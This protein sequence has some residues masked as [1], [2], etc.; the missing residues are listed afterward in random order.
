GAGGSP[1][2]TGL[3]AAQA[4]ASLDKVQGIQLAQATTDPT[5]PGHTGIATPYAIEVLLDELTVPAVLLDGGGLTHVAPL[6]PGGEI[7]FPAPIGHRSTI[8]ALHA[9]LATLPPA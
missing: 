9:E 7:D 4:A 5:P 8:F 3:L 6:T 1:G 2:I